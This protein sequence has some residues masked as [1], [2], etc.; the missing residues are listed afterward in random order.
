MLVLRDTDAQVTRRLLCNA[1]TWACVSC[2]ALEPARSATDYGQIE[3][4]LMAIVT[5]DILTPS[6]Y[7]GIGIGLAAAV[8]LTLCVPRISSAVVTSR[9]A[10]LAVRPR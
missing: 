6:R 2:I 9:V 10:L 4:V 3:L 5:A 1:F 7:R 8:K